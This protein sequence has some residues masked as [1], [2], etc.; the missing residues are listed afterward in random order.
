M[1]AI[2]A[3]AVLDDLVKS[4]DPKRFDLIAK[5][6]EVAAVVLGSRLG[7]NDDPKVK[8]S[9]DRLV[10]VVRPHDPA[11]ADALAKDAK[12]AAA[13]CKEKGMTNI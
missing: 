9:L 13:W 6:N 8:E 5:C 12:A 4:T 7:V 2:P 10:N 11:V 1:S 3:S